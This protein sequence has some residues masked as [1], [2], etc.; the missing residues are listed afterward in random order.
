MAESNQPFPHFG[1]TAV[2]AGHNPDEWKYR[3][4]IPPLVLT[5]TFKQFEPDVHEGFEYSRGG[6]PTRQ[7]LETSIAA[8]EGG[9][10]AR[11][12]ASGLAA[13]SAIVE[14]LRSGDHIVCNDDVYGGTNR[15]F[16]R[17][18]SRF[19]IETTFVNL[20][21]TDLLKAELRPNTRLIWIETPTNPLI[22]LV[23]IAAVCE[24]VKAHYRGTDEADDADAA[25][26]RRPII[27]VDNTFATPYFQ[28]PLSLGAD[29][30]VHSCT[31]YLNGH[32]DVV[33]GC[34]IGNSARLA[35][36]L[37]FAQKAI[38]A[39][40][41]PFDCY[42]VL[43][44][45]RTLH[46]RME[47]HA[48]S[49]LRVAKFLEAHA[50][51][52]KVLYPGLPSHSQHELAVRQ[53]RGFSGMLSFYLNAEGHADELAVAK[54][55][56]AAL[57]L[58]TLA[59]SLGGFETLIEIPAIMTHASVPKEQRVQLGISDTLI[60]VSV[61]LEDPEDLIADL[62]NAFRVAFE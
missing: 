4:V 37:L 20:S 17:I 13:T 25:G 62:E 55:F 19:G 52:S 36:T 8:L 45:I 12:F 47:R 28:R 3:P 44:G 53:M 18:A 46:V 21:K 49:A 50:R 38:G 60:R 40:P 48:R 24:L 1:T 2:R 31:K 5:T 33:G 35:E 9:S 58:F 14:S 26:V 23:D 34:A 54:K 41:S 56:L 57:K 7:F 39:V 16:Q 29:L 43:R 30:V 11:A 51:V 10:F 59:E 6:N 42:L 27:V 61:G 22:K 15:Y 32:S